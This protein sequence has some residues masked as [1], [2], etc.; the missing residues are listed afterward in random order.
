MKELN[1]YKYNLQHIAQ[2]YIIPYLLHSP[3]LLYFVIPYY[4]VVIPDMFPIMQNTLYEIG[5]MPY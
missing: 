5:S 3:Y 2:K 1:K 4:D